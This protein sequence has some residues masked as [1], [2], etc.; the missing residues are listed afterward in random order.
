MGKIVLS[1]T[2]RG[3]Y[4]LEVHALDCLCWGS[5][6]SASV[7]YLNQNV[8]STLRLDGI[9]GQIFLRKITCTS[10]MGSILAH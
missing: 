7:D 5:L 1:V 2:L 3:K 4:H 9:S 8:C 6:P 10:S